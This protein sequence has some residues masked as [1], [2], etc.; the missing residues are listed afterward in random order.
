VP[1]N[2]PVTSTAI[3]SHTSYANTIIDLIIQRLVDTHSYLKA[4]QTHIA[5]LVRLEFDDKA[6]EEFLRARS[7]I[8][9]KRNRQI[10]FEG[11]LHHHIFQISLVYFT[12]IKNTVYIYQ[13]CFPPLMMSTCVKWA[14]EH[15]DQFNNILASQL[16]NVPR[17]SPTWRECMDRAREHAEIL[18]EVGLDFKGLVGIN[19]EEGSNNH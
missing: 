4:T 17:D 19:L 15:L 3:A 12:L 16:S 2:S 6:R 5:W 9:S 7:N 13:Q 1:K 10:L 11:N 14:K 8:I 18:Q